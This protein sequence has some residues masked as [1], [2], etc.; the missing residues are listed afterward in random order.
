MAWPAQRCAFPS[1]EL[2][3]CEL[4]ILFRRERGDTTKSSWRFLGELPGTKNASQLHSQTHLHYLCLLLSLPLYKLQIRVAGFG[5]G[6][7]YCCN[8]CL[9]FPPP[10]PPRVGGISRM[11]KG[12]SHFRLANTVQI[13]EEKYVPP[14]T[15][16]FDLDNL[17][18]SA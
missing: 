16:A 2:R 7:G 4:F 11:P 3:F 10:P 5:R 15:F 18:C 13:A 12:Q 1:C 17:L 14:T 6:Y 8:S 9:C